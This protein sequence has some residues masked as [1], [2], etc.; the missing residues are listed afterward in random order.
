MPKHELR[1][2]VDVVRHELNHRQA[3]FGDI[4]GVRGGFTLRNG[5]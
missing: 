1:F 2:G 5:T 3:E 4:G